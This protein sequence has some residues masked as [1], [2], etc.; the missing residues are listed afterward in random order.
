MLVVL[1]K[2]SVTMKALL[3]WQA[4]WMIVELVRQAAPV[5]LR[6]V[7]TLEIQRFD[8]FEAVLP[9]EP[10]C[11]R[12][13]AARALDAACEVVALRLR[14]PRELRREAALSVGQNLPRPDALAPL[15]M[16]EREGGGE[17]AE[18]LACARG[19]VGCG[20]GAVVPP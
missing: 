3:R 14:A 1:E 12:L 11:G 9:D 16:H 2:P 5:A 13:V 18:L 8:F 20:V 6:G 7:R 19:D 17:A 4:Y 10:P 15:V